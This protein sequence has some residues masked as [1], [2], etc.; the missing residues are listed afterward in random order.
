MSL[1]DLNLKYS[2]RSSSDIIHKDFYQKCLMES[3]RY[4]R[5]VGYFTS[6]SLSLLAEGLE[7][8]LFKDGKIRIVANPHLSKRDVEAIELGYKAK[9]DVITE[10]LLK[11]IKLD[12]STIESDSYNTLAWL[13][14]NEQL[15]IK[16]AYPDNNG[17]YHEKFGLFYDTDNNRV[18]FTGSANETVG[19][20][21]NNFEKIDVFFDK[22]DSHRMNLMEEDFDNLWKNQTSN[23][24]VIDLP[25]VVL[26]KIFQYKNEYPERK[27]IDI[28]ESN[29]IK[30]REY[31]SDA[32]NS[33]RNN[34]WNGIL[35]MA[36]GTGKTFTSLFIADAFLE[37]N[38]SMFLV[39]YAPFTH[40]IEQWTE[41]LEVFGYKN[42]INCSGSKTSWSGKLQS[43]IR[44]YNL[45]LVKK[46]V[47]IT[48]YA[49]GASETFNSMVSNINYNGFLIADECHNFGTKSMSKNKLDKMTGKLGLSATPS[50]WWDE[51]GTSYI[52]NFFNG[53]VYQYAIELAIKNGALSEYKYHPMQT[54]LNEDEIEKY[55]KFTRRLIYLFNEDKDNSE[56]I[57]KINILRSHIL[58]KAINKK[59]QLFRIFRDKDRSEV[60][61]T[62]IYCA[63]GEINII[64]KELSKLKYRVSKFDSSVSMKDRSKI[65]KAFADESI[66]ILV[67]I[68]CLDEG[69]DVPSTQDAYF[70][71]ST[72][73]PRQFVQRRGRVLRKHKNKN[74]ANIYDFIVLPSN[75]GKQFFSSIASKELPRF[76]EFS[77]HAINKYAARNEIGEILKPYHLEYLMDKLPWEVHEEFEDKMV[78]GG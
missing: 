44:D 39:I 8:F 27:K 33:V 2:Y 37:E 9:E 72:S 13:I 43:E 68:R 6:G 73:N 64:T 38:K 12:K 48:T 70:L 31:Q 63:P 17:L 23:L 7:G 41:S 3:S 16:I 46:P 19:G 14:Y 22:T 5:A 34:Q 32:L 25:S 57:K 74:L 56:E 50:R 15:E 30:P 36:T 53:V 67:A 61:N 20:L 24:E 78:Q 52:N 4:D 28:K 77:N 1:N 35:E 40:L 69:V 45:G 47:A 59:E 49:T 51:S 75:T 66:Q 18:A 10:S 65:L 42:I 62:L 21:Q 76:S 71:S 55:E 11:E 26:D 29:P 54:E 58:D 60:A